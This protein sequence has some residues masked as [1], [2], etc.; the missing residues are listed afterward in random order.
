[1]IWLVVLFSVWCVCTTGKC[2]PGSVYLVYITRVS[3]FLKN[4]FIHLFC[5]YAANSLVL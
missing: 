2:T 4:G 3:C 5:G 1:M